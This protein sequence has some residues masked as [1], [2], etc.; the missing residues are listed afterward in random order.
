MLVEVSS[1]TDELGLHVY[2][3]FEFSI[4]FLFPN[5]NIFTH[6]IQFCG[7]LS[8]PLFGITG[9]PFFPHMGHFSF[10]Q[11]DHIPHHIFSKLIAF[12][13][14]QTY[15]SSSDSKP[16]YFV[17]IVFHRVIFTKLNSFKAQMF[18]QTWFYYFSRHD[19]SLV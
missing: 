14:C 18:N 15:I 13:K 7:V 2:L 12:P 11:L 1:Q 9:G 5:P 10:A 17:K 19:L 6:Y 16:A 4:V 8:A 3:F